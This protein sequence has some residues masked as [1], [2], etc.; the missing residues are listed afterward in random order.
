MRS[1]RAAAVAAA[2]LIPASVSFWGVD[3]AGADYAS[4]CTSPTETLTGG[5]ADDLTTSSGEVLL[6]SSGDYTGGFNSLSSGSA[7]CVADDASWTPS[8]ANNPSGS[9]FVQGT[10][11]LSGINTNT[12]FVL[13]NEGTVT[14]DGTINTNG[15]SELVNR[16]D[17]TWTTSSTLTLSN[18][19]SFGNAGTASFPSGVTLNSDTSLDNSGTVTMGSL[20]NNGAV[21]NTGSFTVSGS[22]TAN[23]GASITNDCRMNIDGGYSAN[24][25]TTNDGVLIL[26][27]AVNNNGAWTQGTTGLTSG[28]DLNNDGSTVGYGQHRYTGYTKTQGQFVGNDADDPI[29]FDDTTSTGDI[30]DSASGTVANVVTGDVDVPSDSDVPSGCA[31]TGSSTSADVETIKTGAAAVLAGNTVTYTVT[32]TNLGPDAAGNVVVSDTVDPVLAGLSASD[33]GVVSSGQITWT[34]DNLDASATQAFTVSGTAPSSGTITD[35]VASTADTTDPDSTNNDG[36]ETNANVTTRVVPEITVNHAPSVA[37]STASTNV[38]QT[39]TGSVA[40]S[41][42][43]EGQTVTA[44]LATAPSYGRAVVQ[45]SGTYYYRPTGGF[46][47]VDSFE[48]QGCDNGVPSRCD[49]GTVTITVYSVASDTIVHTA[50]DTAVTVRTRPLIAGDTSDATIVTAP[51]HGTASVNGE[52]RITYTPESNYVGPDA[53]TYEACSPT[54]SDVCDDGQITIYVL[55]KP[56]HAPVVDDGNYDTVAEQ[57]V[58]GTVHATDDDS[59]QTLTYTVQSE[60]SDGTVTLD[61][62]TGDF[63]YT[64]DDDFTG[65]DGFVAEV[66]DDGRPQGCDTGTVTVTVYPDVRLDVATTRE[67]TAVTVDIQANDVGA[68]GSPTISVQPSDGSVVVNDDG[69]V[70]YTPDGGFTGTDTFSYQVCAT[71]DDSV[72]ASA[73][74]TVIVAPPAN[75]PPVVEDEQA[76]TT[77]GLPVSGQVEAVDPDGRSLTYAESTEPSDGTVTVDSDTGKWTYTPDDGFA[78]SDSFTVEVC[79]DAVSP[80]CATAQV[81]ITVFPVARPDLAYTDTGVL[82]SIDVTANDA[83]TV[84][85]PTLATAPVD[86]TVT[87]S[88]GVATYAPDT[89]YTGY[90]GFTYTICAQNDSTVCTTGKVFV[91]V[92]PVAE[93]DLASTEA[94]QSVLIE[95]TANDQGDVGDPSVPSRPSHGSA[96]VEGHEIRYTPDGDYTGYDHFVY[97]VCSPSSD[98]LCAT[99]VV[100]VK[101]RPQ[102]IRD[103]ASTDYGQPVVVDVEANDIGEAGRP[104]IV[105]S[106]HGG[107]VGV[108]LDGTVRYTPL[109]G[110]SG[111]DVFVYER[112]STSRPRV[113][114]KAVVTVEVG[115]R[116]EP[117]PP[118][119]ATTT[120]TMP[121]AQVSPSDPRAR[122][123]GAM[124]RTGPGFDL[125]AWV[126]AAF[127]VVGAGSVLVAAAGARRWFV[128]SPSS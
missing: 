99:T 89:D 106:P 37:D 24:G 7:I 63:T 34:I 27:D 23:S 85:S 5:G 98:L 31:T 77:V 46:T 65:V 117:A 19:S 39:V 49:T 51:S 45:A 20:M 81:S 42:P 94:T 80:L 73:S 70:T 25:T 62:D 55:P 86:G 97:Q 50:F 112:C 88:D 66:C 6:L 119:A 114:D 56:N 78:G 18:G 59:G 101:V 95:V 127:A 110:F 111:T 100:V 10:L 60:P 121:A 103:S 71:A 1:K 64:P 108:L 11:T 14:V 128:R 96:R 109:D 29:V 36:S 79:D 113:C 84:S 15:S 72:C 116:P 82:V 54:D 9:I 91:G 4:D 53:V 83:G 8:Y 124:P 126:V 125:R 122:P 33:G 48:V 107:T 21:D 120:T 32:V 40:M 16:D 74:V 17:G 93:P 123:S 30:F 57:P 115:P 75:S 92:L 105:R 28:T 47:G 52:G 67:D 38:Y 13:D 90:D 3:G 69:T 35:T 58:A 22:V 44:G 68:V 76:E 41:N 12:G 102:V 87:V 2:V 104:E 43:D 26:G 118:P 61:G